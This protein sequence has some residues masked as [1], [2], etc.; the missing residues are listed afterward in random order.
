M[1]AQSPIRGFGRLGELSQ[2]LHLHRGLLQAAGEGFQQAIH[3]L[4]LQRVQVGLVQ[5]GR[6]RA[7]SAADLAE[8]QTDQ[9]SAVMEVLAVF[10][11]L[12]QQRVNQIQRGI[13][14]TQAFQLEQQG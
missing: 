14:L 5:H 8:F 13:L 7:Q 1:K 6:Q 9:L 10:V 11:E 2:F 3:L 4:A 12:L